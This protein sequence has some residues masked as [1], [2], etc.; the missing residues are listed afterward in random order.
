MKSLL[1][2][3]L[4]LLSFASTLLL[5]STPIHAIQPTDGTWTPKIISNDMHGCPSMLKSMIKKESMPNKSKKMTFKNPFDPSS[6]FPKTKDV[7][8]KNIAPNQWEAVMIKA[9]GTI[10]I[11]IRWKLDVRSPTEIGVD[12]KISLNMP[13]QMAQMFGGTTECKVY[14]IGTFNLLK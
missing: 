6:L 14:T 2:T 10:N 4:I 9:E 7:Q 8:W 12:S 11:S 1:K 13:S 5:A 3:T